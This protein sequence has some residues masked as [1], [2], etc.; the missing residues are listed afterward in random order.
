MGQQIA[1]EPDVFL[2]SSH[3]LSSPCHGLRS[4]RHG[5]SSPCLKLTYGCKSLW[6][7]IQV[8]LLIE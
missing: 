3:G 6:V 7:W 8:L 2:D 5:L 1:K 4:F